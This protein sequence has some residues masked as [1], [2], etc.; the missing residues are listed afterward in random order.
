MIESGQRGQEFFRQG[1]DERRELG[2]G[3][4]E[5]ESEDERGGI[6]EQT[7]TR[8]LLSEIRGV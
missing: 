5:N 6:G 1:Q 2:A 4:I 8:S 7:H 3:Q